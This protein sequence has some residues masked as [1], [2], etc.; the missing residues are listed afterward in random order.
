[1]PVTTIIA[2]KKQQGS[3]VRLC[4][5]VLWVERNDFAQQR[6]ASCG[7]TTLLKPHSLRQP[8]LAREKVMTVL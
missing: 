3:K 5:D 1:L 7:G 6:M 8:V 2:L 4:I